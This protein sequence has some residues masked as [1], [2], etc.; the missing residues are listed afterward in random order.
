M[1]VLLVFFSWGNHKLSRKKK[2]KSGPTIKNPTYILTIICM[3]KF[4]LNI[5]SFNYIVQTITRWMD[6]T[7]LRTIEFLIDQW[8]KI[9]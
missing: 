5:F 6:Y 2:K 4:L 1:V 7:F 3:L 9:Y 8:S